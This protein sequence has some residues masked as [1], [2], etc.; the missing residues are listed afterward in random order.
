MIL[1]ISINLWVQSLWDVGAST[2]EDKATLPL[3]RY[4]VAKFLSSEVQ[5]RLAKRV[6]HQYVDLL[7][8]KIRRA[9]KAS[10]KT[11]QVEATP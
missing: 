8:D 11:L 7:P 1:W 4:L 6:A 9:S 2:S 3:F 10:A 5:E